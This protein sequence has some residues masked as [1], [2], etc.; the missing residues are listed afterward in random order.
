MVANDRP[1]VSVHPGAPAEPGDDAP[2]TVVSICGDHDRTSRELVAGTIARAAL[3]DHADVVI[4]L[5]GVTFM[6]ASLIGAIVD[7]H[8]RLLAD[9]RALTVRAPTERARRLLEVCGLGFL[10]EDAPG[11]PHE[12]TALGSWVAVPASGPEAA[13]SAPVRGPAPATGGRAVEPVGSV[14]LRRAPS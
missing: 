10:I 11:A 4:D 1:S 7:G 2:R 8:H 6:D 13:A 9:S 3:L 14:P 5:S 12:A